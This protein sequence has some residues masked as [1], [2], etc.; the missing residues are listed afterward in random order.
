MQD[1]EEIEDDDEVEEDDNEEELKEV[2][3]DAVVKSVEYRLWKSLAIW[4]IK[5]LNSRIRVKIYYW[6]KIKMV[7]CQ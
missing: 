5:L 2:K 1:D 7:I 4:Q 3:E 6:L